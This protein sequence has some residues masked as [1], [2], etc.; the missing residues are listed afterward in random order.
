LK[1]KLTEQPPARGFEG[2]DGIREVFGLLDTIDDSRPASVPTE[3]LDADI[4][5]I[6]QLSL[7]AR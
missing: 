6:E 2:R 5:T 3:P 4:G 1:A 7:L